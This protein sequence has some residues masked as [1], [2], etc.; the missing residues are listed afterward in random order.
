MLPLQHAIPSSNNA[1]ADAAAIPVAYNI[2][3]RQLSRFLQGSKEYH[4]SFHSSERNVTYLLTY[5]ST[6][7]GEAFE[8]SAWEPIRYVSEERERVNKDAPR[9]EIQR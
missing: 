5:L 6:M 8:F 3:L 7:I 1:V 2:V 9:Q 4:F